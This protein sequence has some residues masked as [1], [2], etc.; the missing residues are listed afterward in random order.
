MRQNLF[1]GE[2]EDEMMN[3]DDKREREKRLVC[4][5]IALYCLKNHGGKTL[6]ADCRELSE[7][8]RS[9]S[10]K[11]PFM[12]NKTFCSN[13]KVHCYKP[14]MREK[15]RAVMRFSGPRMIFH[16]PI[17]AMR[18]IIEVRREKKRQERKLNNEV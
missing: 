5:M 10:D 9:R 12:E 17:T 16:H 2:R 3:T 7:Y 11:C 15:I 18:H 1:G 13:C 6:C 8:A 4:Q 14:E